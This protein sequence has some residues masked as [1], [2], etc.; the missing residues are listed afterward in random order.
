[1]PIVSDVTQADV[2][3]VGGG[4][5]RPR[6][7]LRSPESRAECGRTRGIGLCRRAYHD[8]RRNG[9]IVEVGQQYFLSTYSQASKLLDEIGMTSELIEEGPGVQY[10][11]KKGKSR[12]ISSE[13]DLVRALGVRGSADHSARNPS[14]F[15][16]GQSISNL[17]PRSLH[18]G[19]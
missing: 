8:A 12:V 19:I 1:M 6:Y 2:V 4:T 18:R 13:T 17:R 16:D 11:D 14:V 3:V 15:D 5:A 10:I 7:R 9:D